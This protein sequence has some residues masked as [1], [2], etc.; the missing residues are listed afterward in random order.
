[1][2]TNEQKNQTTKSINNIKESVQIKSENHT[3]CNDMF[4]RFLSFPYNLGLIF[5]TIIWWTFSFFFS[6]YNTNFDMLSS[7]CSGILM[8]SIASIIIGIFQ[9]KSKHLGRLG[10]VTSLAAIFS[11]S[12]GKSV[13]TSSYAIYSIVPITMFLCLILLKNIWLSLNR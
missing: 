6:Y 10:V 8:I 7:V 9:E 12:L 2:T 5:V 13:I 11:L 4:S 3:I 1:M